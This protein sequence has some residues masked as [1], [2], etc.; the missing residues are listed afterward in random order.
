MKNLTDKDRALLASS[1]KA[2]ANDKN[3][4]EAIKSYA[5][6]HGLVLP[7]DV[8]FGYIIDGVHVYVD[9]HVVLRIG[10]PP[11]SNYPVRETE[12]TDKYLRARKSSAA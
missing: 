7:N 10:L 4:Q 12:H 2:I 1:H 5:D 11:V 3:V 6:T 9:D 8:V